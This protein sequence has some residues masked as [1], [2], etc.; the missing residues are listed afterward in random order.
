[1]PA[2]RYEALDAEGKTQTGIAEFDT[3]RQVRAWLRGQ[4]RFVISVEPISET[5]LNEGGS[6]RAL[7]KRKLSSTDLALF[8]RQFATLLLAGLPIEQ[9]LMAAQEQAEKDYLRQLVAGVRSEVLSGHSL[10]VA[11]SRYGRDFPEVYR[12]MV[13]AGEQSG[14]LA[15]VMLRLADYVEGRDALAQK[16]GM[17][18]LYP[19]IVSLVSLIVI[20]ALLTYVVPQVVSVFENNKQELPLLTKSLIALSNF[21]R[22]FGWL[23]LLAIAGGIYWFRRQLKRPEFLFWWHQKLLKLPLAGK[24]IRGVNTARFASTLAILV[25]SGVPL[26]KALQAGAD[27]VTNIPMKRAVEEAIDRVREGASLAR[28]L[29]GSKQFPPVLIYLIDSGEKTGRLDEM[30]ERAAEQQSSDMERKAA[31]LT[32]LLEPVLILVMGVIVLVIV[33]A[34]LSPIIEMNQVIS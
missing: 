23:L 24:M 26:L 28:S 9:A 14:E 10:A 30:L 15:Q 27:V 21:L 17:A 4:G 19:A 16:V 7:F 33:L 12:A 22:T 11:M 13:G 3:A 25:S 8:T 29:L 32:T 18:F 6:F 2:F 31:V 20:I 5:S 34:I 1:M